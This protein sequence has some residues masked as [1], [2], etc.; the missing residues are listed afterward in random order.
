MDNISLPY[1][2]AAVGVCC[3]IYLIFNDIYKSRVLASRDRYIE[4]LATRIKV[5]EEAAK[6]HVI[7]L[8]FKDKVWK[9]LFT[10]SVIGCTLPSLMYQVRKELGTLE[11][12]KLVKINITLSIIN[13]DKTS[14]NYT[15][16]FICSFQNCTTVIQEFAKAYFSIDTT[17]AIDIS[18]ELSIPLS[19]PLD[20]PISVV[21]ILSNGD[22]LDSSDVNLKDLTLVIEQL[23]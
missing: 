4:T 9:P 20:G 15:R 1:V 10:K 7:H 14:K 13:K 22:F 18:F 12:D 2:L 6:S 3:F 21:K 16:W 19:Q 23:T 11:A 17:L 5:A 8:V